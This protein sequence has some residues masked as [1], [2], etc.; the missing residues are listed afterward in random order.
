LN[1][2]KIDYRLARLRLPERLADVLLFFAVRPV[3]LAVFRERFGAGTFAPFFLASDNPIAIACFRLDT[4]FSDRPDRRVPFFF[5]CIALFTDFCAPFEYLAITE[6]S[7][8]TKKIRALRILT[9]GFCTTK[10]VS[11][12]SL[13]NQLA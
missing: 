7:A 10:G 6:F 9:E 4:F 1:G 2:L 5:S 3:F 8:H 12:K 11:M 13:P